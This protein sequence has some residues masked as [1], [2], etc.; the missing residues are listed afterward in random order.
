MKK[1]L[2]SI[3]LLGVFGF[4]TLVSAT[5][6]DWHL[7]L[8]NSTDTD[9][10]AFD[11]TVGESAA[12]RILTTYGA[13]HL[14][15]LYSLEETY[16]TFDDING[17]LHLQDLPISKILALQ[18]TL[19]TINSATSTINSQIS[20]LTSDLAQA[21]SSIQRLRVQ[22]NTSGTYIWTFPRPFASSTIPVVEVV[23]EDSSVGMTN[24]QITSLSSTTVTIQVN[25]LSTLLGILTLNS[26]PQVYID[27]TAINP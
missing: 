22:T 23:A 13:T 18:A 1:Y 10:A 25:R 6:Y 27:I 11:L 3:A 20:T 14:P 4:A 12:T 15:R 24:A 19:D 9:D 2:L 26:T 5:A 7:N 16:M 8:R 17:T 21:T